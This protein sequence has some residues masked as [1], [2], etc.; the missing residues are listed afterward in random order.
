MQKM[1]SNGVTTENS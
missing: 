1:N